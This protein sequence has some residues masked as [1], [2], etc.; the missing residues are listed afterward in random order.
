MFAWWGL[1]T[2]VPSFLSL[3]PEQGGAGLN[4]GSTSQWV[5]FMQ[6]GTWL[7]YVSFGYISDRLGR[8][9]TY[10]GYIFIAAALVPL[11]A[12]TRDPM[13]LLWIGPLV[14]FFGTGYFSGFGAITAELF[15]TA[16]RASAQ[17][18][19][20]NLGRGV[21]AAAPFLIGALSAGRGLGF[22]FLLAALS[23]LLAGILALLIPET[24]GRELV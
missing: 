14:G 12:S 21:S 2:W 13:G 8:K 4:I 24:R 16:V 11:Y 3:P 5:I 10:A 19:T 17:G 23:F 18:L 22:A 1:F 15:P 7:G 20:Y 6:V 9:W